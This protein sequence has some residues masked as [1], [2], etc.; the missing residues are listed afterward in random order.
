LHDAGGHLGL[1]LATACNLL[2]PN[3]I[4]VGGDLAHA[5][6]VLMGPLRATLDRY[7]L[8]AAVKHDGLRLAASTLREPEAVG[9]L[10]YGL[11]LNASTGVPP[12]RS[13]HSPEPGTVRAGGHAET[14]WNADTQ[15]QVGGRV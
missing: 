10:A 7:A 13:R 11:D 9:A 3:L 12:A 15:R 8:P 14:F 4:T 1:A 6:E 5:G 2:N